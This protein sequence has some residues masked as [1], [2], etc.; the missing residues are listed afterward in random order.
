MRTGKVEVVLC[1][2]RGVGAGRYLCPERHL[3]AGLVGRRARY[4]QHHFYLIDVV[5][6]VRVRNEKGI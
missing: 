2:W 3:H 5:S 4:V 6:C 1:A